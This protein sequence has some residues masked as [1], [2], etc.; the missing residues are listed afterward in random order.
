MLKLYL[1][2]YEDKQNLFNGGNGGQVITSQ[3]Q[4]A[5]VVFVDFKVQYLERYKS[6]LDEIWC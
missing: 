4:N 1:T 6:Y 3:F 2:N 5:S